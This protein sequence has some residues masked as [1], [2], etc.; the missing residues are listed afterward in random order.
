MDTDGRKKKVKLPQVFSG[1]DFVIYI[2]AL[3]A[4]WF[5]FVRGQG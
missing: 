3:V 5:F 2:G 1:F 4:L